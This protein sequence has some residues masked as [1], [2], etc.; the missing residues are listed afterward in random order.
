MDLPAVQDRMV[1]KVLKETGTPGMVVSVEA[2]ARRE[3]KV[4]MAGMEG[5]AETGEREARSS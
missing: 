1:D 5:S 3:G 2:T 4:E